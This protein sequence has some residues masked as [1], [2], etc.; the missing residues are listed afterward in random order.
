MTRTVVA[1]MLLAMTP[2]VGMAQE[3]AADTAAKPAIEVNQKI[4]DFGEVAKGEKLEA[5]FTVKNAGTAPLEINQVRPTCGCTVADFDHTIPPGG[6][7]AVKA[8]VDTEA[9]S[10]PIAKAVLVFSNDPENPQVNLVVKADVRAFIE[11]LPRPLLWFNALE[12]EPATEKVT[13]VSYDGSPFKITGV[14]TGGGP[15][16][17]SYRELTGDERIRDKKGPQWEVDVTVPANA[18]AGNTTS[19]LKVKTTLA[20]APE[21]QLNA[22]ATVRP[23]IQVLPTT[24]INFGTVP[25]DAPVGRNLIVVNNR[26]TTQLEITSVNVTDPA[27]TTEVIPLQ[28]GQRFQVAVTM[29]PGMAKGR[30]SAT[31]TINTNDPARGQIEIPIQVNVQ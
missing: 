27:F 18:P 23:I 7:G 14:D 21:V 13:L 20:K 29:Q 15:F 10:G 26:Q 22:R 16:E 19:K 24:E 28:A 3:N 9:F 17:V 30:H 12:G 31:M 4:K 2:M 11:V 6:S 8:V 1:T 25:N 5:V